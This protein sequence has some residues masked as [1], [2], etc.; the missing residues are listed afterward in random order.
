MLPSFG[1]QAVSSAK[2]KAV[3]R[4][5]AAASS[6]ETTRA[7]PARPAAMP[8]TTK[9][10]A[11]IMAPMLMA[12]ASNRPRLRFNPGTTRRFPMLD[13]ILTAPRKGVHSFL[14][15]PATGRI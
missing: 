4:E 9:M 6:I 5:T 12:A 2:L 15:R 10:P 13:M 14:G 3:A 11:P 1:C 7:D 8:I